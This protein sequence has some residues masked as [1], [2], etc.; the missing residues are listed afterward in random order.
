[1]PIPAALVDAEGVVLAVNRWL[2]VD[3]GTALLQKS[4]DTSTPLRQGTNG[5]R[6]RVRPVDDVGSVLLAT[7]ER[8]DAGDHLLRMFFSSS[9]ALFVVYD[10]GGRI[11]ESNPAWESLLGYSSEEIFG[12]DS[13][14]LLPSDDLETRAQVEADLRSDGRSSPTFKM[15][16]AEGH[17]RLVQWNLQFDYSVGR[18]F[19]IGRDIT[20]EVRATSELR[21]QATTDALT[22]LA[23]RTLLTERLTELLEQGSQA[24]LLYCDLDR[25]KVVNDSLG[26]GA[27]DGLLLKLAHRLDSVNVG[28]GIL[29]A[30]FGGDEFVVLLENA[31]VARAK[32]V[33]D[34]LM[35]ALK[36]PFTVA[37]RS[38]HAS[39][40]IGIA[41]TGAAPN[42]SA[43]DLLGNADTAVYEAKRQ[44]RG[45]AVLFD[46]ELRTTTARRFEVEDGLR[47]AL[48]TGGIEAWYQPLI[49]LETEKIIGAEALV[50]WREGEQVH[51]PGHFLDVAEEASLMP[52]IGA[53]V[54]SWALEV[55]GVVIGDDPDFVM[56]INVS[57]N[58]LVTAGFVRDLCSTADVYGVPANNVLIEITEQTAISTSQA[59]PLLSQLRRHGFQIALDDFGTGYSSL[60][61]LRDLPIDVVKIDRSF[62]SA[63][64]ED[65]ATRSLTKSL[66]ELSRA[67]DLEVVMEGIETSAQSA[68]AQ[69]LGGTVAQ[70][71]LFHRPMPAVDFLEVIEDTR[72][73][74]AHIADA[75]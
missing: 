61:H 1:M 75:A 8:E 55:A 69:S 48:S 52:S 28:E 63:L 47:K 14:T 10:Q 7:G 17:Y 60:S 4:S 29:V 71:Y 25:F 59:L 6:W 34:T 42:I 32:H 50:R 2:N 24:A 15:R 19:G 39:M 33:A 56:S 16:A 64:N 62:V 11:I 22:G 57:H 31:D 73:A 35:R 21:R 54:S 27:G 9:D 23:N 38:V 43:D 65:L 45:R 41:V 12:V 51:A 46:E 68:A 26:H 66:I 40:S 44:G 36:R 74:N 53:I 49:D 13:W 18:C 3:P 72:E 70:G 37:N 30:R 58:E 5:S 67:L 20:E